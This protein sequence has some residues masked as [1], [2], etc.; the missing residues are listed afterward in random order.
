MLIEFLI[1]RLWDNLDGGVWSGKR[2]AGCS[3]VLAGTKAIVERDGVFESLLYVIQ[4]FFFFSF[5]PSL[6]STLD[7]PCRT[8]DTKTTLTLLHFSLL[9]PH[10]TITS[11]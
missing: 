8:T 6:H 2:E 7:D 10:S 3:W 5:L 1:A 11:R 4:G 9:I